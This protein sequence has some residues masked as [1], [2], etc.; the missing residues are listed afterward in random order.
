ML[1][2]NLAS[3]GVFDLIG[4]SI[5]FALNYPG[6]SVRVFYFGYDIFGQLGLDSSARKYFLAYLINLR[7]RAER[8]IMSSLNR[9]RCS[10]INTRPRRRLAERSFACSL[11]KDVTL[12]GVEV[13][14]RCFERQKSIGN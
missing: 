7:V 9:D 13:S 10:S 1:F 5:D 6:A 12:S 14:V 11:A 3:N 2:I 4:C 8:I